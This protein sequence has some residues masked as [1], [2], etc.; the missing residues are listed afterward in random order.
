MPAG[1]LIFTTTCIQKVKS[2]YF[3]NITLLDFAFSATGANHGSKFTPAS[4]AVSAFWDALKNYSDTIDTNTLF[5][6]PSNVS[7]LGN[8]SIGSSIFIRSCYPELLEI[9]LSVVPTPSTRHMIILGNPG[10]G[11]TF[12]GYFILLN[13]ARSGATVIYESYLEKGIVYLF[14]PTGVFTGE[15]TDFHNILKEDTTFY[16]S[17]GITP[18][19]VS[20]KTILL[21]S[22]R[23]EIW[24]K[25]AKTSCTMRYMPVW[26]SEEILTC[27]HLLYPSLEESLVNEL[28]S[29]WGGIARYVLKFALDPNQQKLLIQA[30][31][32]S[33]IDTVV[34]SFGQHGVNVDASSRLIHKSVTDGYNCGPYEFASAYVVNEMYNRVYLN[35]QC[36][37]MRFFSSSQGNSETGQLRG[38]L[39]ERHAHTVVGKG[40]LFKI[41][42]LQTGQESTLPISTDLTTFLFSEQSQIQN[43]E[44]RYFRPSNKRFESVDSFIKPN[45]LFQMTGAKNHP[46]KQAG[47]LSVLTTLGK[48]LEPKLYFVVP[49]DRFESFTSQRYQGVKG[50]VLTQIDPYVQTLSQFVLTFDLYANKIGV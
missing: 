8:N 16:I 5:Q 7:I 31:D 1:I 11:K 34:K 42:D 30:F 24:W 2:L 29:K 41:R 45:I 36:L 26:S 39:F 32:E 3:L 17:D 4:P 43:E 44:N 48:P 10:I 22:L 19:D 28:Y 23:R 18:D 9:T 49:P 21:T 50:R 37:L 13:L 35:D 38:T 46:C 40:G 20:A 25:F 15:R 14:T 33:N 27:R 47:L 12:F 6:L